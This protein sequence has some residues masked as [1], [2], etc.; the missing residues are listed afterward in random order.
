MNFDHHEN[1]SSGI[2]TIVAIHSAHFIRRRATGEAH[3][4]PGS[5]ACFSSRRSTTKPKPSASTVPAT[6]YGRNGS[7][8]AASPAP[9]KPS[10]TATSGPAQQSVD[11]TA[12]AT[13]PVAASTVLVT[14]LGM[15]FQDLQDRAVAR[16]SPDR[17]CGRKSLQRALHAL[18]VTDPLLDDLDL[19]SGFPL[20]GI[21]CGAVTDAQPEQL[22]NLLQRETELLGVLDEAEARHRVV[23]VLAIPSRSAPRGRKEAP[24]LVIADRLDVHVGRR[25]DLTDSQRHSSVLHETVTR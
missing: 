21:A 5:H 6:K 16:G 2:E 11:A 22:L 14:G 24:P 4:V 10:A 20:D 13:P 23:G 18:E 7:N 19:L 15:I 8:V 1:V 9:L 12:A 25:R 3:K 17:A